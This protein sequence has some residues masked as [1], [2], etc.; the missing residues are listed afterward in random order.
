[1]VNKFSKCLAEDGNYSKGIIAVLFLGVLTVGSVTASTSTSTVPVNTISKPSMNPDGRSSAVPIKTTT[2][3]SVNPDGRSVT[4]KRVSVTQP[5]CNIVN[6][7]GKSKRVSNLK[8]CKKLANKNGNAQYFYF[9]SYI[10]PRNKK[11]CRLFTTC[12]Q[13]HGNIPKF[14]GST[15][16]KNE[17]HKWDRYLIS[18]RSPCG[19]VKAFNTLYDLSFQDCI[20]KALKHNEVNYI[21]FSKSEALGKDKK[22]MCK[23]FTKCKSKVKDY[24]WPM[25]PGI[26]Y[27]KVIQKE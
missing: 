27:K 12:D 2:K 10:N 24:R 18:N 5:T 16:K 9:G 17:N 11:F 3:P 22:S 25:K 26:T 1:M 4:W 19:M 15:F 6:Q 13:E 23:H 8:K 21:F 7:I 14:P 20:D